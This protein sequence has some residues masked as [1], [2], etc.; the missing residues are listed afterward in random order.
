[1]QAVPHQSCMLSHQRLWQ[2]MAAHPVGL[3]AAVH[4][5]LMLEQVPLCLEGSGAHSG[6]WLAHEKLGMKQGDIFNP[7]DVGE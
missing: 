1:M 3:G 2:R 4:A 6:L 7:Y 5:L